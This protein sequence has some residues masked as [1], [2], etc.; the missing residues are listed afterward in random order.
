MKKL[1][2]VALMALSGCAASPPKTSPYFL[3]SSDLCYMA[4]VGSRDY[5]NSEIMSVLSGRA[6]NC[7][8]FM[9]LIQAKVQHRQA[10]NDAQ[11]AIGLQLLQAAQPRPAPPVQMP[12]LGTQ[13]QTRWVNGVAYTN[14]N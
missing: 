9:P 1:I 5:S 10:A 14:C 2:Y 13:C 6:E 11:A 4:V 7:Q 12:S 3:E 8:Q